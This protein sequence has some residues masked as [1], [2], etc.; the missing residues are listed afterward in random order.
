LLEE[1]QEVRITVDKAVEA[2]VLEAF[3]TKHIVH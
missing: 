1:E 2:A 3:A